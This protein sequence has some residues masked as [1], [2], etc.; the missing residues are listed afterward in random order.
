MSHRITYK[1]SPGVQIPL[2]TVTR[3]HHDA[4]RKH[5]GITTKFSKGSPKA[6]QYMGLCPKRI[7]QL[8]REA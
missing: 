2:R 5:K 3:T 6:R 1:C 8:T 7:A 4:K